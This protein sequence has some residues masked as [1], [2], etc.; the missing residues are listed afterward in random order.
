MMW[1]LHYRRRGCRWCQQH[2]YA[3]GLCWPY[4]DGDLLSSKIATSGGD[5][6]PLLKVIP[7]NVQ[8]QAGPVRSGEWMGKKR[9][10]LLSAHQRRNRWSQ[11]EVWLPTIFK[12]RKANDQSTARQ[13]G[14]T[15]SKSSTCS[16]PAS[17][18]HNQP[19]NIFAS[20]GSPGTWVACCCEHQL[21]CPGP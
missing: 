4:A 5:E 20:A 18:Q 15:L 14:S 17:A 11:H 1:T 2:H 19:W 7:G 9:A 16:L 8:V 21:S 3:A 12:E 6:L 10:D 13:H